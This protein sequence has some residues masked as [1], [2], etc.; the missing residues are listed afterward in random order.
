[1]KSQHRDRRFFVLPTTFNATGAVVVVLQG[2]IAFIL[3]KV[4]MAGVRKALTRMVEA[5]QAAGHS[6]FFPDFI[7]LPYESATREQEGRIQ[8]PQSSVLD[9]YDR[10]E[11]WERIMGPVMDGTTR[12]IVNGLLVMPLRA[13]PSAVIH[14]PNHASWELNP[15]AQAA[16]G[17]TIARW[18]AG[19]WAE[20][21]DLLKGHMMPQII[22]P[23][24]A[25]DKATDPLFR[26]ITD[27]RLGNGS[28]LP[29]GV[30]YHGIRDVCLVLR[31]GDF[32]WLIDITDAYHTALYAG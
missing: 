4:D 1:V 9:L 28:Y 26:L 16:L 20:F 8:F 25:V 31:R 29:W 6:G 3:A 18:L 19:G 5:A 22:E 7:R 10:R 24:G 12:A 23:L 15:A 21:I 27:G 30:V 11:N 17:P 2:H 32:F 13:W 14:E